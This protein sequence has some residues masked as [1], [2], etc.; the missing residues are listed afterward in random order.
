MQATDSREASSGALLRRV[1]GGQKRPLGDC[2]LM[3]TVLKSPAETLSEVLPC[4]VPPL[5]AP[6]VNHPTKTLRHVH[7]RRARV[8]PPPVSGRGGPNGTCPGNPD[9]SP[10]LSRRFFGA[11][12]A[13]PHD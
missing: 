9:G 7:R 1:N 13:V 5:P 12:V 2:L 11:S 6:Q 3:G 10:S 8:E 4:P